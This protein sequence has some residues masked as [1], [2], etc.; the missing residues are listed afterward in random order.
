[1]KSKLFP[2]RRLI[3]LANLFRILAF[4]RNL[5]LCFLGSNAAVLM[6]PA[7][8]LISPNRCWSSIRRCSW[9]LGWTVFGGTSARRTEAPSRWES[10]QVRFVAF[11]Q[12]SVAAAGSGPLAT[13]MS[14]RC[15][16]LFVLGFSIPRHG[17]LV[18]VS[19]IV[20]G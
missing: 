3:S 8:L 13:S 7:S 16:R 11:L 2:Y 20:S 18:K 17:R 5:Q 9:C 1:M 6:G 14:G 4:T 12:C 10:S 19:C 15:C